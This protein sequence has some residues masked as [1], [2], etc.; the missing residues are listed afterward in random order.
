MRIGVHS[1]ERILEMR[2]QLKTPK[3]N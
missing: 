3:L 2:E 1:P